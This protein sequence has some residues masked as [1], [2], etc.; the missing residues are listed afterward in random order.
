MKR[1]KVLRLLFLGI[2]LALVVTMLILISQATTHPNVDVVA[3]SAGAAGS[4]GAANAGS[5][6]LEPSAT[7][8]P[9]LITPA[10]TGGVATTNQS[11]FADGSTLNLTEPPKDVPQRAD[12]RQPQRRP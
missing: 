3:K 1:G 4:A 9:A 6:N 8:G 5:I 11:G 2:G 12:R 7:E 10:G